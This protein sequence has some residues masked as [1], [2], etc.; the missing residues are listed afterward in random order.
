[1]SRDVVLNQEHFWNHNSWE[2]TEAKKHMIQCILEGMRKHI[3]K[4]VNYEKAKGVTQGGK[5]SSP[6]SWVAC[7]GI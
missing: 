6:L 7:G 3:K 1:M 5:K 4:R 2:G